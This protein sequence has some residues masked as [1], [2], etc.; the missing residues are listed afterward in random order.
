MLGSFGRPLEL[1]N[2]PWYINPSKH[3][4]GVQCKYRYAMHAGVVGQSYGAYPI[5]R[6]FDCE[7]S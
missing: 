1:R 6:L 7:D 3:P 5:R 2:T 4:Y